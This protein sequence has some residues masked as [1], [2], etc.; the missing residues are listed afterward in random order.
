MLVPLPDYMI[1]SSVTCSMK[2]WCVLIQTGHFF[3][4]VSQ[5]VNASNKYRQVLFFKNKSLVR[6]R[7][8]RGAR[9]GRREAMGEWRGRLRLRDGRVEGPAS[10]RRWEKEERR[11]IVKMT[12]LVLV[13]L[14]CWA[15]RGDFWVYIFLNRP[16]YQLPVMQPWLI[17][18]FK[19]TYIMH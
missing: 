18:K 1:I 14:K 8:A 4:F 2:G 5:K 10:P 17:L 11:R 13:L 19:I 15:R 6:R 3:S 9:E 7:G 16:V 12:K